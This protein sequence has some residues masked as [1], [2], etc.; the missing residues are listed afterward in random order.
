[1][2]NFLKVRKFY[3]SDPQLAGG[4]Y[5]WLSDNGSCYRA[6]DTVSFAQLIDF[7]PC[8]TPG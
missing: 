4:D 3:F 7:V 6:H 8:F 1:M 5:Q 2:Q